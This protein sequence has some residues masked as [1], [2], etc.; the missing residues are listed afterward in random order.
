[1]VFY[2]ETII[3]DLIIDL[4]AKNQVP[5]FSIVLVPTRFRLFGTY[6]PNKFTKILTLGVLN[7]K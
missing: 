2:K 5:D 4:L 1:M 7:E 3:N 6:V